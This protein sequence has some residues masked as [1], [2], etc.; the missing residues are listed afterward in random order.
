MIS[1]TIGALLFTLL[2]CGAAFYGVRSTRAELRRA[3][4][5]LARMKADD[6]E[7]AEAASRKENYMM[8]VAAQRAATIRGA[9][10]PMLGNTGMGQFWKVNRT[11]FEVGARFAAAAIAYGIANR[12]RVEKDSPDVVGLAFTQWW[13]GYDENEPPDAEI[14][15]LWE[16]ARAAPK[17]GAL[18]RAEEA[19]AKL[20][21]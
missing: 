9:P 4:Q 14:N 13:H 8:E 12:A 18:A 16:L 6:L 21:A 7:L 2:I 17:L 5:E 20:D 1:T 19:H 15:D 10:R 11:Q 3:R